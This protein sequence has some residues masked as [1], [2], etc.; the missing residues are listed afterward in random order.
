MPIKFVDRNKWDITL[1]GSY[2][3]PIPLFRNRV[4]IDLRQ[5]YKD[6]NVK[7]LPFGIGYQYRKGTSNLMLAAKK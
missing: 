6:G 4:Q 5:A 2:Y 1:F 3:A 7:P